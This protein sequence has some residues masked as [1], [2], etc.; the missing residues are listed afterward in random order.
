MHFSAA[1]IKR[2]VMTT[3]L[4]AAFV[5]AGIYGYFSLPVSEL[6]N[7]DFQ[8]IDDLPSVALDPM[9]EPAA[10]QEVSTW[11]S[12]QGSQILFIYGQNDP[13]TAA[14][15]DLGGAQDS[16]AFFQA[17]GNHYSNIGG[18]ASGDQQT[19]LAALEAWTGVQPQPA[20][21]VS[22]FRPVEPP[23]RMLLRR[24]FH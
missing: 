12:T 19:A 20:P 18:L 8:T 7:V 21:P 14:A 15:F 16:F 5:I 4:M 6:H 3:L 2:P 1:F 17:G 23:A 13:W 11:L 22:S 9:F 24:R 10:M